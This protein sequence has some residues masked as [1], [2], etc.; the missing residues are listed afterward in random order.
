MFLSW[1]LWLLFMCFLPFWVGRSGLF[2]L[3]VLC[4]DSGHSSVEAQ[5]HEA[6]WGPFLSRTD[7]DNH[8]SP[9]TNTAA[10]G[11]GSGLTDAFFRH[12]PPSVFSPSVETSTE[13]V[14]GFIICWMSAMW[15]LRI[16]P[17]S[18]AVCEQPTAGRPRP[19]WRDAV[20]L[21]ALRAEPRFRRL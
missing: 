18:A 20:L 5:N 15:S 17:A 19:T 3:L 16:I 11:G 13:A 8:V 14:A 21:G 6:P 2:V 12:S 9:Q 1:V 7:P 10:A 4:K